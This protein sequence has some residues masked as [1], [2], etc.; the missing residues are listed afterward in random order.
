MK[1]TKLVPPLREKLIQAIPL[2]T[3]REEERRGLLFEG[4]VAPHRGE[5]FFWSRRLKTDQQIW[6]ENT[7]RYPIHLRDPVIPKAMKMLA[8]INLCDA[9][10]VVCD[11][12]DCEFIEYI[13]T[14]LESVKVE[15][16]NVI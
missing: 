14:F 15:E 13:D 2:L 11:D 8:A 16:G 6:V 1:I 3:V 7:G 4:I 12:T 5:R 9:E 10:H